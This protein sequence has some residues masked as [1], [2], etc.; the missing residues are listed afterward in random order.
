MKKSLFGKFNSFI[1]EG[2]HIFLSLLVAIIGYSFGLSLYY[3]LV[4]FLAGSFLIDLDHFFN[5]F[6]CRNIL[7]IPDYKGGIR[8]GDKGYAP[9]IFHGFDVVFLISVVCIQIDLLFG[10]FLFVSLSLHLLWDFAVYPNRASSLFFAS[11]AFN[12]FRVGPRNYF[13][14]KIFDLDTLHW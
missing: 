11:R 13:I 8:H 10:M 7:K 5:A 3:S 12:K 4:I 14:G 6:I 1:D 2:V 9:K